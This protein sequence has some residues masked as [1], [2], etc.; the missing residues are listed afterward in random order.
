[1]NGSCYC[2]APVN[3]NC[4]DEFCRCRGNSIVKKLGI[5]YCRLQKTLSIF[6]KEQT[7]ANIHLT[8]MATVLLEGFVKY[9][10]KDVTNL[11]IALTMDYEK[12]NRKRSATKSI[13]ADL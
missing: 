13:V 2:N 11:E 12:H 6:A 1:M 7:V 10:V 5:K 8:E 3:N 9:T 4:R